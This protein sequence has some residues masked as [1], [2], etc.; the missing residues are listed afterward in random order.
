MTEFITTREVITNNLAEAQFLLER[1]HKLIGAEYRRTGSYET[2]E[3]VLTIQGPMVH[4]DRRG[5]FIAG[6][7]NLQGLASVLDQIQSLIWK[8]EEGGEL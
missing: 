7:Q 4:Q 6:N 2:Q 8:K 1:N 5:F 3:L